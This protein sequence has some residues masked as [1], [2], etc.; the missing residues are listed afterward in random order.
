MEMLELVNFYLKIGFI[1]TIIM[2][3]ILVTITFVML[4]FEHK[5]SKKK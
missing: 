3:L 2:S 1:V 4:Y 5:N